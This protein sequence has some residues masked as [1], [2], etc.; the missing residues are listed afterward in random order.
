MMLN[1]EKL[2][3]NPISIQYR[4]AE[5][6]KRIIQWLHLLASAQRRLEEANRVKFNANATRYKRSAYANA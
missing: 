3:S 6:W 5:Y 2:H 1:V 4:V